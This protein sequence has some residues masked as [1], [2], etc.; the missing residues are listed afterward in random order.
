MNGQRNGGIHDNRSGTADHPDAERVDHAADRVRIVEQRAIMRERERPPR[1]QRLG[2]RLPTNDRSVIAEHGIATV[3]VNHSTIATNA[4]QRQTPSLRRRRAEALGAHRDMAL[5][6]LQQLTLHGD[7]RH[8]DRDDDDG[9]HRHELI[10]RHRQLVGELEEIGREHEHV[11]RIAEHERQAEQLETE[12]EHQHAGKQDGGR[13]H[14]QTD[15]DRHPQR[16]RAGRA[17]R[18]LEVAA[19]TRNAAAI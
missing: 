6:L 1:A 13:R 9:H 14:R 18:L 8:G 7:Q 10:R 11:L 4:G 15:V 3:T 2:P 17:R 16:I 5:R 12:K 19:E